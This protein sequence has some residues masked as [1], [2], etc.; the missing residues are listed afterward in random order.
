MSATLHSIAEF[1]PVGNIVVF[2]YTDTNAFIP[3]K[4][5]LQM[6]EFLKFLRKIGE[7]IKTGG[8]NSSRLGED[9]ASL[10]FSPQENLSLE[11]IKEHYFQRLTGGY[12]AYEHG[13][14]ACEVLE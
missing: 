8:F 1:A 5:S 10:G 6:K 11:D 4:L 14:F 2:N 9:L 12:H 7:P 3:E 13:Y